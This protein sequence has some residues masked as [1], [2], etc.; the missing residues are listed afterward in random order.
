MVIPNLNPFLDFRFFWKLAMAH[1]SG[2]YEHEHG[3][4]TYTQMYKMQN[5]SNASVLLMLELRMNGN[6]GFSLLCLAE[7]VISPSYGPSLQAF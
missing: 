1:G 2:Q 3:L 6:A 5:I 4:K 7:C